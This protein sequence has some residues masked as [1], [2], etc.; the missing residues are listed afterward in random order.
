MNDLFRG[1]AAGCLATVPM[2]AVM[3]AL[4]RQLPKPEKYPLP[5]RQIAMRLATEAGASRGMSERQRVAWTVAAHFAMGTMSGALYP[6]LGRHLPLP[7][8]LRGAAYGLGVWAAN[9]LGILPGFGILR[10]ATDKPARRNGL[11]IAAHLVWGA[12]TALVADR[13]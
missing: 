4:H 5:P 13:R 12:T 9:Y 10:P 2:T 11:M 1:A 6:V 3:E 7:P 8:V